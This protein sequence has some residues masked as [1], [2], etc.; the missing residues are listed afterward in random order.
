MVRTYFD[1]K[2][3]CSEVGIFDGQVNDTSPPETTAPW[4]CH[5]RYSMGLPFPNPS[6]L[7]SKVY[8]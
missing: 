8:L 2:V 5:K 1:K 3:P 6:A 7:F 4:I